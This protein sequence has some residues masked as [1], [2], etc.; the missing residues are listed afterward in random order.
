MIFVLTKCALSA[1]AKCALFVNKR[2]VL[3]L[4][5]VLF[6]HAYMYYTLM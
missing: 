2:V 1:L 5:S 4:S 6:G 3:V